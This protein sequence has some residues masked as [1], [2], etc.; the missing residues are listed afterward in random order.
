M[1]HQVLTATYHSYLRFDIPKGIDL[2][3]KT[4]V[5]HYWTGYGT[6]HIEFVDGTKQEIEATNEPSTEW[7]Y[8]DKIKIEEESDEE[9]EE[10]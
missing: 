5:K 1:S 2:N 9:E 3:D 6:L 10:D 8:P 4:K 7:N